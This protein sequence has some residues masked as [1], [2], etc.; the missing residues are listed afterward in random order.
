MNFLKK[1]PCVGE[2]VLAVTVKLGDSP[3]VSMRS[4]ARMHS[5]YQAAC[6]TFG[7][8]S[9]S[10]QFS[11]RTKRRLDQVIAKAR[12]QKVTCLLIPV[13][14]PTSEAVAL[15]QAYLLGKCPE[16][17]GRIVDLGINYILPRECHNEVARYTAREKA[18][19]N[20]QVV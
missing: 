11:V 12:H 4:H 17:Q 8:P 9:R 18:V 6:K 1:K 5:F 19:A 14:Q 16:L 20:W 7:L 3:T 2:V 10:D 13:S 15:A